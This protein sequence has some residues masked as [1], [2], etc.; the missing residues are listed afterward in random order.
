MTHHTLRLP[1]HGLAA[2]LLSLSLHGSALPRSEPEPAAVV[3]GLDSLASATLLQSLDCIGVTPAELGFDKLYAE[4]DTFRLATVERLL[5]DPLAVF[6]FQQQVGARIR[7]RV[8]VDSLSALVRSLGA[9]AEATA[10]PHLAASASPA[11]AVCLFPAGE[12]VFTP[13]VQRFIQACTV[14]QAA[15]DAALAPLGDGD[16][17]AVLMLAPAFWGDGEDPEDAARKGRL[18]FERGVTVD[19]SAALAEDRILDA[20]ARLDRQALTAASASFVEA[21]LRLR[22]DVAELVA[23]TPMDD[24]PRTRLVEEGI[25][26]SVLALY[27]T[28]WGRFLVGDAGPNAYGAAALEKAAFVVD[29]GGD[30]VYRGRAASAIGRL[31]HS[32]S[33]VVDLAGNDLYDAQGFAYA[34]GGCVAGIAVLV[35]DGGNDVYRGDDGCIGAGFFGTGVVWDGGGRDLF[36]GRNLCQGAGAFGIGAVVSC[37]A[38]TVPPGPLV[39]ED[40]GFT[41]GMVKVP[42]TGAVPVRHDDNDSY[43]CARQSQGFGSTFGIGL[44]YDEA[45]NDA[46]RSGGRYLHRPLLPHDF[47][48]LSQGFSIGFRPRAGGGVGIL[49]DEAGNDFYDAEVY[50]QG[51]SYWYSIGL[52]MDGG[53]NDRY[54]ATQYAQGAGIHLSVGSLW[55]RGGDD[56]YVCKFGVTQGTSHDLS[57][58][59]LW[60][61]GGDDY[62]V[63]SDGQGMSIT[64]SV[65]LFI[66]GQGDDLY[67]TSGSGQGALTWARGFCGAGVFIDL[68]G[69]DTYPRGAGADSAAWSSDLFAIG[70][71]LPRTIVLPDEVLPE[72]V[73]TAADSARPVEELFATASLWEVGSARQRVRTA[74]A[75][76]LAKAHEAMDYALAHKLNTRDG[77]EYRTLEEIAKAAPDSFLARILPRL[78]D[79]DRQT[80]RNA[81]GLLG[82]L[83]RP[84]AR[85]PLEAM[86]R[87]RRQSAEWPR[88]INA[89]G[90]IG[91]PLA[92]LAIRPFLRDGV[93]RRRLQAVVALAALRDSTAVSAI[94]D[95]LADRALTVRSAASRA[96]NSFGAAAIPPLVAS[97]SGRSAGVAIRLRTLGAI[98]SAI[99]DSAGPGA[100][101]ARGTARRVLMEML[102]DSAAAA[103]RAAA[104]EALLRFP[105]QETA[106]FVR[107]HMLDEDDPLVRGTFRRG[108]RAS[109][110]R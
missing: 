65:A 42:G 91:D 1:R 5:N 101:R 37:A 19:T 88:V 12:S 98:A 74:R 102:E 95:L 46:Y 9:M 17:D 80:V 8:R 33:M 93:E 92:A 48:S 56:H 110:T 44:L 61:E 97:L 18:H 31:G 32:L 29:V 84:E 96:L 40:R 55:D 70:T 11:G 25:E 7:E 59:A 3:A 10:S 63:V 103:E 6:E 39:E 87:D 22:R 16:L 47:Q 104:I 66:D 52:L 58:G 45:G 24:L 109:E 73:L 68:E 106:A 89:L 67:A 90:T 76:L 60:D 85:Q 83:K 100:L 72:P 75:A 43:A 35:D 21:V 107:L 13:A 99:P 78:E 50:A 4:D 28:P 23:R 64:N 38:P 26:G 94:T 77:L 79:S 49:C 15:L 34:L 14:S 54:L 105:D 53:G 62:Y 36:E 2:A 57:V 86:L 30:D 81:I 27:D 41:S 71:D 108:F 82:T 51:A 69:K 20:A